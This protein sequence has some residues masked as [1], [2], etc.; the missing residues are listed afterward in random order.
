MNNHDI[1]MNILKIGHDYYDSITCQRGTDTNLAS[2]NS[3]F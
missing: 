2:H 3:T 1:N